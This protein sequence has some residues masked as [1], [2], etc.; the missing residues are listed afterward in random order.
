MTNPEQTSFSCA[1]FCGYFGILS[2]NLAIEFHIM[3][4]FMFKFLGNGNT[5]SKVAALFSIVTS[6]ACCQIASVVSDCVTPQTA[7]H[8]VPP[9][10]GFSRQE[11]W[12][13]LPFPSPI[14][15]H[16]SFNFAN[17]HQLFFII[18]WMTAIPTDGISLGLCLE[19]H[20]WLTMLSIY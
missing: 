15:M 7:A 16:E 14:A 18:Y 1:H 11:H 17:P 5:F 12:S 2:I 6:N 20:W 10:L 9:S 13:G 4:L 8:Q 3:T 19:F